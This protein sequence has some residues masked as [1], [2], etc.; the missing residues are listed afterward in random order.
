MKIKSLSFVLFAVLVL[1]LASAPLYAQG[2]IAVSLRNGL[3]D[4][5][6]C[7]PSS[8]NVFLNRTSGLLKFCSAANTWSAVTASGGTFLAG[9]GTAAA[10]SYSFTADPDTGIFSSAANVLG[11]S[12]AG[13]EQW[14]ISASCFCPFANAAEDI[15]NGTLNPRDVNIARNLVLFGST[16]GS[17]ILK[18]AA[19]AGS[20]TI[21]LPG[22]T[23]DFSATGGTSQVV[24]Q[25]SAGGAFTVAQLAASDLSNGTTGTTTVVLS[26]TPTLVTPV[27]GVAGATSLGIGGAVVGS[28]KLYMLGADGVV[29]SAP[30]YAAKDFVIF[31]NNN[32]NNVAFTT[33][34]A[35]AAGIKFFKSGD[36]ST[37]SGQISYA[38]ATDTLTLNVG[39]NT[40][41]VNVLTTGLKLVNEAL[42]SG[43][44]TQTNIALVRQVV[45]R[46]DWTNAM[47]TALGATTAGDV[48]IA[49]LP[50]KTIVV[51]AYIVITGAA[52]GPAAVTVS[53]GRTSA[54]YI[55][56]IVASD[57]KA[58]ANTVYGDASAE[59][60][61]NLTG[62]DLPSYT[63]TTTVNAHFIST[64]ANLSTVAA[65]TGAIYLVTEKL[66]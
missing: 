16:S 24:K 8:L 22:G 19:I 51:N 34:A 12:A 50:A 37:P 31:E 30:T 36:G 28:S 52:T 54:S 45:T 39:S 66:P 25:T 20:T 44:M 55:D 59:R 1:V 18:A 21:T 58:A 49:V 23:T 32:N 35:N 46:L 48:S 9:N 65:S 10:P 61:T 13:V 43:T 56:Y 3:T 15:G 41:Q 62:Y 64:G 63:G 27:L 33:A 17:T 38:H 2:T 5:V 6:Q 4:P 7:Q 53:V 42:T 40:P 60:G 26:N 47:V 29:A 14:D 11:L 57:A